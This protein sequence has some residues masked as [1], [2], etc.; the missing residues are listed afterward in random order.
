MSIV[1]SDEE[2][3]A[4]VEAYRQMARN[5]EAGI[6][7]NRSQIYSELA[8]RFGR[9][10]S[11]FEYR[12]QNISAV[13]QELG[14]PWIPGLRPAKHVGS[15]SAARL[16]NIIQQEGPEAANGVAQRDGLVW[17]KALAA[18][19]HLGGVASR[20]Q[21]KAWILDQDPEY[22]TDNLS[23]LYML[24]VNSPSR[25]SYSQNA[26][27]RRT[28]EGSPF[29]RL[30]KVGRGIF[31][32][33]DPVQHGVWEIYADAASGNRNRMSIRRVS[34]PVDQALANAEELAQ[35][36]G[37]FDPSSVVDSRDR[38][39][40]EIVRRR[41]QPAFR[42]AL[43]DAYGGAC[44]ITGC[45]LPAVLE[46]AHVHPYKGDDTNV[47][48]NGLLLRADIH[49]LFDLGLIAIESKNMCVR[50]SPE[51][52]STSYAELDG[53]QL[54]KPVK[55]ALQVSKDALD[56]HRSQCGWF[57]MNEDEVKPEPSV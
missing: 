22:D 1:W 48:S 13:Y 4:A 9:T 44:V 32:I 57:G 49:T 47:V 46:A 17:E 36:A 50:V 51:L 56:W 35:Q 39:T 16:I 28:D 26:R 30:F 25:T 34:N 41:G 3:R 38:V 18:V 33:Y 31:E 55:K 20:N 11:A 45:N 21:V 10:A 53:V 27:P 29:D 15:R 19:T 40:A 7:F 23:D 14:M 52:A 12:M 43:M 24:S 37:S 6:S 54:H 42:K 8:T 5:Q 2:L